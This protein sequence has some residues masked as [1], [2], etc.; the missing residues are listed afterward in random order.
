MNFERKLNDEL[1]TTLNKMELNKKICKSGMHWRACVYLSV[2]VC[3]CVCVRWVI[4]C[5]MINSC[6]ICGDV[7]RRDDELDGRLGFI[8]GHELLL[9]LQCS[10]P[11]S[12]VSALNI[13]SRPIPVPPSPYFKSNQIKS[14]QIKSNQR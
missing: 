12:W 14:N 10:C 9:R 3:V 7:E 1:T 6:V 11:P 8:M 4:Q 2:C 5:G 13:T